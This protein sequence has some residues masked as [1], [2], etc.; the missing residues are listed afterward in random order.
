[1]P[2]TKKR[3]GPG[4]KGRSNGIMSPQSVFTRQQQL[5]SGV[6]QYG[7]VSF[8][9]NMKSR[10][11]MRLTTTGVATDG[12]GVLSVE[13]GINNPS[14]CTNWSSCAALFDQ[15]RVESFTMTI[16][17][18]L[19]PDSTVT[20][21]I[22][23][24]LYIVTDYDATALSSVTSNDIAIQYENTRAYDITKPIVH[25]VVIPRYTAGAVV[26]G[27]QDL[28]APLATGFCGIKAFSLSLSTVYLAGV[29]L[30]WDV[31]FRS[32]R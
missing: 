11:A 27:W 12:S 24:P 31:S 16:L 7:K 23:R 9:E 22:L 3:S 10:M 21:A 19:G 26:Q 20:S 30:E 1:M 4:R 28:A 29:T 8:R 13:V 32:V 18:A 5:V 17:P 2:R 15:Y 6:N 14:G 25:K